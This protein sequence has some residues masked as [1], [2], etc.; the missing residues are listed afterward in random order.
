MTEFI[1]YKFHKEF[2]DVAQRMGTIAKFVLYLLM[3]YGILFIGSR[4][5]YDFIYFQF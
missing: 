1:G 2:V 5:S 4:G 3:L